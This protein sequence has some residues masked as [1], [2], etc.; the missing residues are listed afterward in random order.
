[1][2][3]EC[4]EK[5]SCI[6]PVRESDYDYAPWTTPIEDLRACDGVYKYNN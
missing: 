5:H 4:L 6:F 2:E 3:D 1:M